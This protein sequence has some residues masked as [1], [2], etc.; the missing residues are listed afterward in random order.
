MQLLTFPRFTDMNCDMVIGSVKLD[1]LPVPKQ[2]MLGTMP[3][4]PTQ[5][6]GNSESK[7]LR[8]AKA[9]PFLGITALA[10][11]FMWGI[12]GVP[13]RYKGYTC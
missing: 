2:S 12:V 10:I 5:G 8:A 11:Y 13:K 7:L 1:Y 4:N 6:M 9:L 3:F